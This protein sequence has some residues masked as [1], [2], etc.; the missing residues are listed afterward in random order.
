[1]SSK[2]PKAFFSFFVHDILK[3]I[4]ACTLYKSNYVDYSIKIHF[5]NQEGMALDLT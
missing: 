2:E 4:I 5:T 3:E 1:M